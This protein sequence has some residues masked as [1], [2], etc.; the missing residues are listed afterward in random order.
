M[1]TDYHGTA[2]DAIEF[3]VSG[4]ANCGPGEEVEFLRAWQQGTLDEWPE[5]YNWLGRRDSIEAPNRE[6]VE[7]FLAETRDERR[8]L[9]RRGRA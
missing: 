6:R 9:D 5:Y 7:R 2:N 8:F 3:V 4:A 1:A